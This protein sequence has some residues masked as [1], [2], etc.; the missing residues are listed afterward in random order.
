MALLKPT[1]P[2]L[3]ELTPSTSLLRA[4]SEDERVI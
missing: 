1:V 2:P 4:S 3:I